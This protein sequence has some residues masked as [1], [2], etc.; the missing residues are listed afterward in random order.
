M[1]H[2]CFDDDW[3]HPEYIERSV[4][5][6]NEKVGVVFC[7]HELVDLEKKSLDNEKWENQKQIKFKKLNIFSG[8]PKVMKG[9]ISPSCALIRRKD[10]ISCMYLTNNLISKKSYAGVGPDWLMTAFPI[11]EYQYS[12]H[13]LTP[14]VKFG[15]HQK[16]ITID[17]QKK[18]NSKKARKFRAAYAGARLYLIISVLIRNLNLEEIYFFIEETFRKFKLF[19]I[20]GKKRKDIR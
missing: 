16:S 12:I 1:I 4:K 10:C 11:F 2:F 13:I 6:F 7:E 14:L 20:K 9:L 5:F 8:F 17:A 19:I 3:M 18:F 15:F